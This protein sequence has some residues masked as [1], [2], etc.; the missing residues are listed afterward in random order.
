MLTANGMRY[1]VDERNG[2]VL[3]NFSTKGIFMLFDV[4]V[5]LHAGRLLDVEEAPRRWAPLCRHRHGLDAV[6]RA[7]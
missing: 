5:V 4:H 2:T 7:R 1:I 6:S 3:K